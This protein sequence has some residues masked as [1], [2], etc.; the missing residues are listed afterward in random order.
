MKDIISGADKWKKKTD[1]WKEG[2][3]VSNF[4]FDHWQ[5][6]DSQSDRPLYSCPSTSEGKSSEGL[7]E[8]MLNCAEMR[9]DQAGK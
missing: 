2:A 7:S 5:S 3:Q 9:G 8:G 6:V 1:L 4:N